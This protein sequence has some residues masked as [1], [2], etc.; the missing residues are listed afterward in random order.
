MQHS[1]D[2]TDKDRDRYIHATKL[3]PGGHHTDKDRDRDTYLSGCVLGC[4]SIQGWGG[5]PLGREGCVACIA[6]VPRLG[7]VGRGSAGLARHGGG[8]IRNLQTQGVG[9]TTPDQEH[10]KMLS[11]WS[12]NLPGAYP[13]MSVHPCKPALPCPSAHPAA[14]T[15][16]AL[17]PPL[18]ARLCCPPCTPCP[19]THLPGCPRSPGS[20]VLSLLCQ[21][22]G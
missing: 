17:L 15:C 16:Y 14:L 9:R 12:Q 13:C 2:H 6:C 4:N 5:L 18:H 10:G 20:C 8:P 11:S 21:H 3:L 22:H 1:K 7:T 19:N